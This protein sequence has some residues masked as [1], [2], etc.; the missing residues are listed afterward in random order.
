MVR[1]PVRDAGLIPNSNGSL[2]DYV[3][4]DIPVTPDVSDQCS[5]CFHRRGGQCQLDS[6][7]KFSCIQGTLF[8]HG[9][10]LFQLAYI[11]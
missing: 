6:Q 2:F 3:S 7:G 11:S 1:L 10:N 5:S 4:A 8:I 9:N